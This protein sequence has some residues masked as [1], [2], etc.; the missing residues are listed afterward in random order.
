[1]KKALIAV[2]MLGMSGGA[3]TADFG[4][5]V[6]KPS[7]LQALAAAEGVGIPDTSKGYAPADDSTVRTPGAQIEWVTIPG[8]KFTMGDTNEE[9]GFEDARPA[10]EVEI[11]TFQISKTHVTVAQYAE[12]VKKGFCTKPGNAL[13]GTWGW[14]IKRNNHPVNYVSWEQAQQYARFMG[15]RLPTEAE[16]EYAARSGGKSHRYPWG[17][18]GP[19][20]CSD[21][22]VRNG[23]GCGIEHNTEHVCSKP[24]GNT[25]QGLCDMAGNVA[26]WVQDKYHGS[27]KG[28]PVDGSAFEAE[29]YMR[30]IRGG[31]CFDLSSQPLRT[32]HRQF[33]RISEGYAS[34]G[35]R[36]AR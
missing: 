9:Q 23:I 21:K 29:G 32:T 31:S 2:V 14:L 10:H 7:G 24:A 8:G 20:F 34:V 35:F 28:A 26:Q 17:N 15:A 36:I 30:V 13:Y 33:G 6:V 22:A 4:D 18:D 11:K 19:G 1:M 27:Y 25:D 5:I 12:C 3:Y 16:W